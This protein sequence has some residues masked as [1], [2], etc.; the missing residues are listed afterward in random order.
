[1]LKS[2]HSDQFG[3]K[4]YHNGKG[5]F[6]FTIVIFFVSYHLIS[7]HLSI[8]MIYVYLS[9][10]SIQFLLMFCFCPKSV[11]HFINSIFSSVLF[12]SVGSAEATVK[13]D[14]QSWN[15]PPVVPEKISLHV[16]DRKPTVIDLMATDVGQGQF[17]EVYITALPTKGE[18]KN[19]K[20]NS[21]NNEIW[22]FYLI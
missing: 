19:K 9:Y 22:C 14:I 4:V 17:I 21:Q 3:Y 20:I 13:V 15:Y 16:I 6:I 5:E 8:S 18:N 11:I 10:F 2:V 1:M 12:L 7:S